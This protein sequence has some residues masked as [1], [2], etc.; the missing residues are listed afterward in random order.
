MHKELKQ[1]LMTGREAEMP[2]I[3]SVHLRDCQSC[4]TELQTTQEVRSWFPEPEPTLSASGARSLRT[5]LQ[6]EAAATTQEKPLAT[7]K[8]P[9]FALRFAPLWTGLA[10]AAVLLFAF[11]PQQTPQTPIAETVVPARE[12][13]YSAN[14]D[15][16]I[17]QT[18]GFPDEVFQVQSGIV[19][20]EVSPQL[21]HERVRVLVGKALVTATDADFE[22]W[23]ERGELFRIKVLRGAV[24]VDMENGEKQVLMLG[25]LWERADGIDKIDANALGETRPVETAKSPEAPDEVGTHPIARL[26]PIREP[27]A[28]PDKEA[29]ADSIRE[30]KV[31]AVKET[32]VDP[33]KEAKA[34]PSPGNQVEAL[35]AAPDNSLQKF[36]EKFHSAWGLIQAGEHRR[37]ALKLDTLLKETK[38]AT[39]RRAE[40]MYWSA[41]SHS[42]SRN[43]ATAIL[44]LRRAL[45][46]SP[47][48]W[49]ASRARQLLKNLSEQ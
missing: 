25:E 46:L 36:E 33:V 8:R 31:M 6:M 47:K 44:R 20:F 18:Q 49:H 41:V 30:T 26:K 48:G 29:M 19:K 43:K 42:K 28:R 13:T 14:S 9:S 39:E 24:A 35:S 34:D 11:W 16:I 37:A 1:W 3:V 40:I 17:W 23:G 38:L 32:K 27:K 12:A 45:E 2:E 7:R 21:G 22:L 4:R 10:L 5:K 15:A